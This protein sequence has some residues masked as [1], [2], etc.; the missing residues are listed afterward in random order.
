M[1]LPK[2]PKVAK[3]ENRM[4]QA[5]LLVLRIASDG[6]TVIIVND[7]QTLPKLKFKRRNA[8]FVDQ[9]DGNSA[10]QFSLFGNFRTSGNCVLAR[11]ICY[12]SISG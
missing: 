10:F 2:M 5:F 9:A 4:A 3:I 1:Q 7:C 11:S 6:K 8:T 12:I